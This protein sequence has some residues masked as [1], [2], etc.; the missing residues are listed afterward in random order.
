[1]LVLLLGKLNG[2][3][4]RALSSYF[5]PFTF[6]ALFR[7]TS[8]KSSMCFFVAACPGALRF[9]LIIV[10]IRYFMPPSGDAS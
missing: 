5:Q 4:D 1:M 2:A 10:G 8:G 6:Q 3:N 9:G 7:E